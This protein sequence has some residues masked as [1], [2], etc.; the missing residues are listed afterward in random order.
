MSDFLGR[1]AQRSLGLTPVVAPRLPSLFEPVGA[2]I[3]PADFPIASPTR[4]PAV[5]PSEAEGSPR[6]TAP[7]AEPP[8]Y[9]RTVAAPRGEGVAQRRSENSR[10]E[11][12]PAPQPPSPGA[13]PPGYPGTVAAPRGEGVAQRRS[14]P[15]RGVQPPALPTPAQVLRS[16]QDDRK[17]GPDPPPPAVIPSEA[18]GSPLPTS[19]GAEP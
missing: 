6:P 17:G 3:T 4:S 7:G 10:G 1:L 16:A 19:P 15:G 14:E 8:G 13:Q 12:A 18:E 11:H 9:P 2:A 5:I